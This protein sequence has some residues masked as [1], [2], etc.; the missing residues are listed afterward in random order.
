VDLATQ[1]VDLT[2]E[3]SAALDMRK[4]AY[5]RLLT[6][7]LEGDHSRAPLLQRIMGS[8]TSRGIGSDRMVGH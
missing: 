1:P 8:R 2:V 6:A 5:E 7:A 3:F 4:E